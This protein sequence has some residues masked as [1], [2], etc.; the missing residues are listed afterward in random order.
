MSGAPALADLPTLHPRFADPAV[1]SEL[2]R[3]WVRERR[4]RVRDV[5]APGLAARLADAALAHPFAFFERHVSDVRCVFWRQLQPYDAAS[6]FE[7]LALARRLFED[8]LP[9][10]ASAITGQALRSQGDT[11]LALDCYLRGS[12]LDTHTDQ[13]RDRLV[14]Y[15]VGLTRDRWPA[16]LGGH[17]EF[18][19]PDE[20][21]VI[22]R[23]EPG[24]DTLDLFQ[25]YPL[26]R[27][28]RIPILQARVTRLTVN[29]WLAGELLGPG[30]QA[31]DDAAEAP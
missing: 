21:T 19:W 5:L 15:V 16:E 23:I 14:A 4:L 18:L 10:L 8:D 29:G 27:P 30:E 12:Y 9:R 1:V 22:D 28:H 31:R 24:F 26:L 6:T 25:I 7:P 2:A 20:E 3:A 11:A 17:L 13:G